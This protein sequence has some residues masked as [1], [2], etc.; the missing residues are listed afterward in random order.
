MEKLSLKKLDWYS[1]VYICDVE[2]LEMIPTKTLLSISL[3]Y[4]GIGD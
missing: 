4:M 2:L 3:Y 1:N